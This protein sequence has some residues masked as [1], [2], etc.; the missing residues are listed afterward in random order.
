MCTR[1]QHW[2]L[3]RNL[4]VGLG[5]STSLLAGTVRADSFQ[6]TIEAG[7]YALLSYGFQANQLQDAIPNAG[8]G[9]TIGTGEARGT[10]SS[11]TI[12]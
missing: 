9:T 12:P 4:L 1:R 11:T 5:L 10:L 6:V 8:T 3:L 7:M 2:R